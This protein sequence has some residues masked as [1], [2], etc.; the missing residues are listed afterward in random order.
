MNRHACFTNQ[1][2][3]IS[4]MITFGMTETII[5]QCLVWGAPLQTVL[6]KEKKGMK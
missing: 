4:K 1:Q 3:V 6:L 2:T 5:L